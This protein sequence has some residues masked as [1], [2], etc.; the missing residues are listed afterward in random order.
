MHTWRSS[1]ITHQSVDNSPW[2][3]NAMKEVRVPAAFSQKSS[4][5]SSRE[6][7]REQYTTPIAQR[8]SS[9]RV[10]WSRDFFGNRMA[11][12][13]APACHSF[14]SARS[15]P[16][17]RAGRTRRIITVTLQAGR[18]GSRR[19]PVCTVVDMAWDGHGLH[20]Y[21]AGIFAFDP[22]I[23]P[24]RSFLLTAGWQLCREVGRW[25]GR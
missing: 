17:R 18:P 8:V 2:R 9:S 19:S 24:L 22:K 14:F 16:G 11:D 7:I 6:D 15:S 20:T 5:L 13:K 21:I 25:V 1:I 4:S 10:W 23:C 3:K 12:Y